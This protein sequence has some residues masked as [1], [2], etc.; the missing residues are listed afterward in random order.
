MHPRDA[1]DQLG[2][3]QGHAR[4]AKDILAEIQ[5]NE[6]NMAHRTISY[7]NNLE[8]SMRIGHADL[9]QHAEYGH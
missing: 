5:Y 2:P 3:C 6:D 8:R 7:A 9:G 1:I 4:A